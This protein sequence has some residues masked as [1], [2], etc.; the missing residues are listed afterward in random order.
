VAAGQEAADAKRANME[1]KVEG[2]PEAKR[3]KADDVVRVS[4]TINDYQSEPEFLL[5]LT[6]GEVNREDIPKTR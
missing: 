6:K 2:P 5:K 3:L 4:G 1:V